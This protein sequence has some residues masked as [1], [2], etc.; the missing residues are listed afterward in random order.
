MTM[1]Y[2]VNKLLMTKRVRRDNKTGKLIKSPYGHEKFF[3]V[4][5][6][7]LAG[8]SDLAANLAILTGERYAFVV[9]GEPI[10]ETNREKARRLIYDDPE[11]G[12]RA[13]FAEAPRHW[14]AVDLDKIPAPAL[15]DAANDPHGTIDY[16]IGLLPPELH[17]ASCWWQFTTSQGLPKTEGTLSAR[18]WF[19]SRTPVD[20]A[21]LTRWAIAANTAAGQRIV[22]LTLY[23]AVQPHYIANPLFDGL[24]DP[25][26]LR[27]GIR[28]GLDE[29]I[30]LM[31]PE[32]DLA[33]HYDHGGGGFVGVG[34][35][36]YLGQIGTETGFRFGMVGAIASYFAVNGAAADPEPIKARLR[37]AIGAA[38]RGGRG[39][40]D[41][42]RYLSDR[43]LNDIIG[44][45]R[46]RER[47]KPT[48]NSLPQSPSEL[49]KA[50]GVS[51]PVGKERI[52]A[53]KA[54]AQHLLRQRFLNPH[55]A[56]SLVESWNQ[57]HCTPPLSTELVRAIVATLATRE[58]NAVKR[59]GHA[60]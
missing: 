54:I 41:I 49:L 58:I 7:G 40:Q 59:A 27:C 19:W 3:R 56:V 1:L 43:H 46:T 52:K 2:S 22:D 21:G 39:D 12:D 55:L 18:L 30:T 47:A 38:P 33:D 20:D 45:V 4:R 50:V 31:I 34:V 48:P 24:V 8:F 5:T 15:T 32:P 14:F 13:T 9:R 6:V 17:D 42:N 11:T 10:A 35:D 51:I 29:S 57:V 36:G 37:Q 28:R 44:W 26:P 23:R 53:T 60:G 16:L 25:L